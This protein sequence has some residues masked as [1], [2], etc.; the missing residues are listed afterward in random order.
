MKRIAYLDEDPGAVITA[1]GWAENGEQCGERFEACDQP[2]SGP[3][4]ARCP[5]HGIHPVWERY[6][7][8]PTPWER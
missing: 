6:A 1:C 8:E 5:V 2:E 7:G 3:P 4:V